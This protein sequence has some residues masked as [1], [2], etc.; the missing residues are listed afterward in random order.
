MGFRYRKRDGFYVFRPRPDPVNG[1][2][3]DVFERDADAE[4]LAFWVDL[5]DNGVVAFNQ[6]TYELIAGARAGGTDTPDVHTLTDK[7]EIG[8]AY[9]L[10]A[11][12]TD[13]VNAVTV[14]QTYDADMA[15]Q[16]YEDALKQIFD[17]SDAS[18][19]N[20]VTLELIGFTGAGTTLEFLLPF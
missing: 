11:G 5:L 13:T 20:E 17:F 18:R 16:T 14:M 19:G 15:M 3:Q 6:L 2:Y 8:L 9:A 1:Y 7:T 10:G 12:L 4:G